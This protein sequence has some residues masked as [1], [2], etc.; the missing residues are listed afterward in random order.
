MTKKIRMKISL[1]PGIALILVAV[2]LALPAYAANGS[3]WFRGQLHTHTYWSDGRA[4]PEQAIEA[5]KERGY[6]FLSLT[7][8]NRFESN[9]DHWCKLAD[10]EGGWPPQVTHEMFDAYLQ[11]CGEEWVEMRTEGNDTYVRIKT[12]AEV[13]PRYEEPGQFLLLPG[14]EITQS[15]NG[16]AIHQNYINIPVVLPCVAGAPLSQNLEGEMT[17]AELLQQ[18]STQA[19]QAAAEFQVPYLYMVNHPFWV[20]YDV[21]PQNLI[22]CPEIRFFEICN[23]GSEFAPHPQA[24]SYTPDKFWDAVN[25]FRRIRGQGFLYGVGS[26]DAHFYDAA[27]IDQN[28]GV[29]DAWVMVRA[30]SL[31]PEHLLTALNQGDFYATTGVLLE[32]L[33]FTPA[34]KTLRVKIKPEEDAAYRIHFITTKQGFDQTLTEI[35]SPAEGRRPARNV[36]VYSEDI[37]RTVK[38]VEGA[39]A[40]YTLEE[41]DLY[42]RARIESNVPGKFTRHFHPDTL[43]AWTQPYAAE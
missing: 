35:A 29:G 2:L 17:P 10:E 7:D 36:P 16:L 1:V 24:Q 21:V 42:V 8:H 13:K 4:F 39:E 37:G 9:T 33:T 40:E 27:R 31:T 22:D 38:T 14:V 19:R 30:Q 6:H 3:Q 26:D 25:A 20:Y 43:T 23:G 34:D 12:Y 5:Y 32:D 41:D 11:S 15:L 28:D 18:N